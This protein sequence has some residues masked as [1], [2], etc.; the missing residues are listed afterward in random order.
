MDHGI[1]AAGQG[2]QRAG[3]SEVA[4]HHLGLEVAPERVAR[5]AAGEDPHPP[6]VVRQR[7]DDPAAEEAGRAGDG[8]EPQAVASAAKAPAR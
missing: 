6:A 4:Q 2:R 7:P 1:R 3:V 5:I 8:R